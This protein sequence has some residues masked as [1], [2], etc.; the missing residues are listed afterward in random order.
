MEGKKI[1][2]GLSSVPTR[3]YVGY[4]WMSDKE[5]QTVLKQP[6]EFNFLN[7]GINHFVQEALLYSEDEKIS[8]MVRHTGEY[9]ITEFNLEEMLNNSTVICEEKEYFPHRLNGVEKVKITQVWIPEKDENCA[10]MEVLQLKAHI[11]TGFVRKI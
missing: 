4:I 2:K 6:T 9:Q 8:V 7:I 1:H 10:G 11:F 3:K 5:D